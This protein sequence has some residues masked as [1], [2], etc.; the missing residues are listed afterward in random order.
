MPKPIKPRSGLEETII[1]S[2]IDNAISFEYEPFRIPYLKQQGHYTPDIILSNGVII[3]IKGQFTK[4][5]RNKHLLIKKQYPNVLIHFIFQNSRSYISKNSD[6]TYA[7]WCEKHGFPY[8]DKT[9]PYEWL[10]KQQKKVEI[11]HD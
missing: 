6:T 10:E 9:I 11:P 1:Q 8:A 3:E 4:E 2:L 5:D 7:K